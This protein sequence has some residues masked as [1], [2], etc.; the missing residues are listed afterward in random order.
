MRCEPLQDLLDCI[1]DHRGKTPKKLGGDFSP[2]GVPVLS[3][4][5]IKSGRIEGELRHVT[6]QMYEKWMPVPLKSGDVLLTSEAPL[7]E[8]HWLGE[9]SEYVLGQRLFGLRPNEAKLHSGFLYYYL[10][11]EP[12]QS[13]LHGRASGSTVQGIRQSELM[14]ISVPLPPVDIQREIADTLRAIDD[15]IANNRALAADLEAMARA[16]FNSWFVN[17]DPV[18]AKMEGRAPA[19]MDADTAALFPDELVESE[20]GLIPKGW[21]VRPIGE[22]IDSS[23]G[24]D[25]GKEVPETDHTERCT[26]VR[27]TDL[28]DL[29]HCDVSSIPV[30]Y[31]TAKKLAKRQFESWDIVFEVSGGSKDQSTGRSLLLRPDQIQ[32]LGPNSCCA[33]FCRRFRFENDG[34]AVWMGVFLD[35]SYRDGLMWRYQVQSTGISNFQTK[36]FLEKHLVVEPPQPLLDTFAQ[37]VKPMLEASAISENQG[38]AELRDTLLPRLISG[39]LQLPAAAPEAQAIAE[40]GGQSV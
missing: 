8:L 6:R 12:G 15:K 34:K 28:S 26:I 39:K 38:L 9:D 20:L 4:K 18:K 5:N 36:V 2:S 40:K 3:A 27:G 16:I 14:R 10:L 17:F 25:W 31:V 33:S 11:T 21:E 7:G 19:G 23:L 30:R 37:L 35:K 24:G 32:A 22:L 1:I 29:A 13:Q